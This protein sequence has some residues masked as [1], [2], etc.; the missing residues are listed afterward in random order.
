MALLKFQ[1]A[2]KPKL[3]ISSGSKKKEPRYICLSEAKA[4]HSQR[5]WAEVSSL[6][7]HFLHKELSISPSRWRCLLRVLWPISRP[8]SCYTDWA[9]LAHRSKIMWILYNDSFNIQFRCSLFLSKLSHHHHHQILSLLV[10]QRASMKSF[11]ALRSPAIPLTSFH[12]LL[13][14]LI[15][16][17]IV[18]RHVLF[19]LPLLLYRWEFQSNA[20]FSIAP[21]SLRN[22]CPIQFH[23]LLFIWFSI[24]FWW[25]ILHSSWSS[26]NM[27][28]NCSL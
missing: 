22:V 14:L 19:G 24:D 2:P 28:Y 3:L 18:L 26:I 4:S 10:Q 9:I 11:Q 23:F 6:T 15:S 8:A 5:M 21:A 13:V 27:C 20:V 7:P 1:M 12:D 16:S 25:V 17:S